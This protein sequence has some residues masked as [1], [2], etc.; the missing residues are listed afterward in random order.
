MSGEKKQHEAREKLRKTHIS[1]IERPLGDLVHL[2]SHGNGLHFKRQHNEEAGYCIKHK[3][4]MRER[5][6]ARS[7]RV[8][9]RKHESL[10][11]HRSPDCG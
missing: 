9:G 8:L 10:L 7:T 11:C 2:P 4:R 5:H 3:I 1:E 6:P